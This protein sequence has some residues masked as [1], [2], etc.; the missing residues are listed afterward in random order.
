MKLE[1]GY[2]YVF[3]DGVGLLR[4]EVIKIQAEVALRSTSILVGAIK[5][6]LRAGKREGVGWGNDWS[7]CNRKH[8]FYG[9]KRNIADVYYP[10]FDQKK[11][12]L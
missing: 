4:E 6:S 2:I 3:I 9:A 1:G 5:S 12:S 7:E 10:L 8:L 11:N